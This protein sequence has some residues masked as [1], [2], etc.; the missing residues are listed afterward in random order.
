M[1]VLNNEPRALFTGPNIAHIGTLLPDGGPHRVPVM[2]DIQGDRIAI[3]VTVP[4]FG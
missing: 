4:T 3:S 1:T 2:V